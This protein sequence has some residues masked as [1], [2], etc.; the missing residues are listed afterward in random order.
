[1][2]WCLASASAEFP[3]ALQGQDANPHMPLLL[4]H[5]AGYYMGP[6]HVHIQT[7]TQVTS[8]HTHFLLSSKLITSLL[9][10]SETE[11]DQHRK[12]GLPY[13]PRN[14]QPGTSWYVL[15]A[16]FRWKYIKIETF[17]DQSVCIFACLWSCNISSHYE[18]VIL[19]HR[20]QP[21]QSDS[22]LCHAIY[23]D[24]WER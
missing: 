18:T 2:T 19:N 3:C 24:C 10:A 17:P 13:R 7:E 20:V 6:L 12:A 5:F 22:K 16:N 21:I 14:S 23:G 8:D 1:M 9:P 15:H 4:N 11:H